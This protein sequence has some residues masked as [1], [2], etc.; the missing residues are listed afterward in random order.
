[1]KL[2]H[3]YI[4]TFLSIL[5]V[6]A[7][8]PSIKEAPPLSAGTADFSS[9]IA[10]GNSITSGR[11][12][13]GIDSEMQ[14]STFPNLLAQQFA[15]VGGGEFKQ[16]SVA[17]DGSGMLALEAIDFDACDGI[18]P[19]IATKDADAS[20]AENISSLSLIHI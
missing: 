16:P 12:S 15:Q 6:S 8:D 14:K 4:Y 5:L 11:V 1:M 9:Y 10:I 19:T 2:Y 13:D 18:A 20:W 3:T 7:C 17:G